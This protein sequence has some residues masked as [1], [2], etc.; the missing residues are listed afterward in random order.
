MWNARIAMKAY[1]T[2]CFTAGLLVFASP[3]QES[4]PAPSAP[5]AGAPKIATASADDEA[6]VTL[7]KS[8]LELSA[9]LKL[10]GS[11]AQEHRNRA[12]EAAKA[13]QTQKA[14]WE[15][16][17]AKELGEKSDALL[18]QLSD[19]TGQRQAFEQAHKNAAVS[20]GSLSAAAA[21]TRASPQAVEF[22][23]KL[24]ERMDRVN[25]ELLAARQYAYT[26]AAQLQ[27]NKMPF[28][29]QQAAATF[30]ENTRKIR[31]L[32]REQSD[33]DLKKLEF[34]ALRKP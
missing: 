27:T 19:A 18:K 8:E 9:Q 23:T 4:T 17:L 2:V 24:G 1:L 10:V 31:Q 7:V 25:Q 6:Y 21:A 16:E 20:V 28:D 32:E 34:E 26:Y 22:M 30:E 3:A 29:Y 13:N 14:V 5:D 15:T 33:L 11:L 12:E